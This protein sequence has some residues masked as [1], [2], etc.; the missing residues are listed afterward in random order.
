MERAQ[1]LFKENCGAGPCGE[2]RPLKVILF[3]VVECGNVAMT[4]HRT[5]GQEGGVQ[6][7]AE[8]SAWAR[9]GGH[10]HQEVESY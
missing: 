7:R 1:K 4:E 3:S 9:E 2:R 6:S 5:V 8:P 10:L